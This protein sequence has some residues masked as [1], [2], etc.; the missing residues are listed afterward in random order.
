V[1]DPLTVVKNMVRAVKP[2]GRIVLADDDHEIFR[3][4]PE[5]PGYSEVWRAYM[6]TYDRLGNDPFV[7]RRLVDLLYRA[8]AQPKRNSLVFFGACSGHP[9]FDPMVVILAEMLEGA[10]ATIVPAGL[11]DGA[12]YD[13][14]M[15]ALRAWGRRPD[16]AI[17]FAMSWAE[18]VRPR[19]GRKA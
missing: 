15:R 5:P 16:A 11:L 10:R 18:G 13:E 9:D 8:G 1:P 12:M 3:V 4:W 19:R 7:G 14:A 2:G 17:W 6:R